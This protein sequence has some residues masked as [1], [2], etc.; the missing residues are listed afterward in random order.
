MPR[1][2][3]VPVEELSSTGQPVENVY[4]L[5]SDIAI[6]RSSLIGDEWITFINDKSHWDEDFAAI[7]V[8]LSLLG[9]EEINGMWECTEAL[10]A[11]K[12]TPVNTT[13]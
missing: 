10:P 4:R 13:A 8:R 2:N 12:A 5:P 9:V 11:S 6:S 1:S 3:I 7:Y